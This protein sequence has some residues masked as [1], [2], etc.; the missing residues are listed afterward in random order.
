[1]TKLPVTSVGVHFRGRRRY[2]HGFQFHVHFP[3][4]DCFEL[5]VFI[6]KQKV[7]V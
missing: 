1:M 6:D 5:K 3:T 2:N 4:R 7:N